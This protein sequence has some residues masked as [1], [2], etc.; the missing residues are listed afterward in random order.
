M[1]QLGL[2]YAQ[3][4]L[5][6]P[7]LEAIRVALGI[8]TGDA[9]TTALGLLSSIQFSNTNIAASTGLLP[10]PASNTQLAYLASI[11]ASN[12]LAVPPTGPTLSSCTAPYKSTGMALV[13]WDLIGGASVVFATFPTSRPSG[14]TFGSTFGITTDYAELQIATSW[15]GWGVYVASEMD[16]YSDGSTFARYP[17]NKWRVLSGNSALAFSVAGAGALS[18]TLCPPANYFGDAVQNTQTFTAVLHP[19]NASY[20]YPSVASNSGIT[21]PAGTV[22]TYSRND[23]LYRPYPTGNYVAAPAVMPATGTYIFTND[24]KQPFTITVYYP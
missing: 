14:V 16:Q 24:P 2:L 4:V 10:S 13:P 20:Y 7:D 5:Q 1:Q 22:L 8:P 15:N 12:L 6:T 17:T 3:A 19:A 23:I 9:T 18:V 21:I 11:A